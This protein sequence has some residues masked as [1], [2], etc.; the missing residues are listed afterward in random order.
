MCVHGHQSLALAQLAAVQ[1]PHPPVQNVAED[2]AGWAAGLPAAL[3]AV[4]AVAWHQAF[5]CGLQGGVQEQC[6]AVVALGRH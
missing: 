3:P 1:L 5:G 6:G 2:P 4:A